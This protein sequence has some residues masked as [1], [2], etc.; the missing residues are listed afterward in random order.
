MKNFNSD[1][2]KSVF[3]REKL[4]TSAIST[5]IETYFES[6]R[7]GSFGFLIVLSLIILSKL[8]SFSINSVEYF[9]ISINDFIFSFWGFIIL[10]FV[11]FISKI[12]DTKDEN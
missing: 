6:F 10:S 5:P 8:L 1:E 12:K 4:F 9:S 7:S 3:I 2:T 11:V